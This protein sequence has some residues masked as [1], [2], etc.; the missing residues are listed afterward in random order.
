MN[1]QGNQ[2]RNPQ[3]NQPAPGNLVPVVHQGPPGLANPPFHNVNISRQTFA[4]G[5]QRVNDHLE[6]GFM[7]TMGGLHYVP[8]P[9]QAYRTYSASHFRHHDG[10]HTV[11]GHNVAMPPGRH[12]VNIGPKMRESIVRAGRDPNYQID[13]VFSL[14]QGFN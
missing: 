2:P 10:T 13:E 5:V 7:G 9:A 3:G 6:R 4:Q 8:L 12:L 1:Q 11:V 14:L